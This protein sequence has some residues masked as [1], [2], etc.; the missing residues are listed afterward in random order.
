MENVFML[1]TKGKVR[2]AMNGMIGVEDLW[3]LSLTK[4]DALYKKYSAEFEE[5]SKCKG[6]LD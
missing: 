6:L 3:D 2:F 1:A 4:L 5:S